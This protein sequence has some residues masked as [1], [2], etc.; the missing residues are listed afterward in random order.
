M[1]IRRH[2]ENKKT[3]HIPH[4]HIITNVDPFSF[5]ALLDGLN[6]KKTGWVI[7]SK[8]GYTVETVM[9]F[10]TILPKLKQE[11]GEGAIKNHVVAITEP[12]DNPLRILATQYNI[13]VLNH[14]PDIGG[15]YS[16]LSVVGMLPTLIAGLDAERVRDGAKSV[17]LP[18]LA[19][20]NLRDFPPAIGA[21]ISVGLYKYHDISSS[22]MLAYS[23]R[24][25]SLSRWYRQLWAESLGKEGK[26]I[27]PIYAMGPVD[28]HSQLQLW[29][30]GPKDKMFTVMGAPL[31]SGGAPV[32]VDLLKNNDDIDYLKNCTLGDLMEA[33]RKATMQS[34]IN[35]GLPVREM[36]LSCIDEFSV[37]ALMMHFMLETIFSA[38]LL[39]VNPFDQPAVETGKKLIRQYLNNL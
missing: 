38:R 14:N 4:I 31:A 12:Y 35:K 29:L 39:G 37:G 20:L 23:D 25:G 6:L 17:L 24:L 32:S 19:G 33:S 13:R 26:G 7:V 11:L 8:S 34:L 3:F 5:H 30:D 9:Q 27:T 22:V 36:S 2:Q 16:V 1:A 18:M 10:L 28:Q 21:A 15:R